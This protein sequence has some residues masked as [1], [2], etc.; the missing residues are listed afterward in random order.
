M[1]TD[2]L[3]LVAAVDDVTSAVLVARDV[4][5]SGDRMLAGRLDF[6][7]VVIVC[8]VIW[9]GWRPSRV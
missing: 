4:Q 6:W 2:T 7:A 5:A 8:V 3:V 9:A 1:S